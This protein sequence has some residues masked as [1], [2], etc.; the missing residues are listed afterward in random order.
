MITMAT[1]PGST[2][3]NL[4]TCAMCDRTFTGTRHSARLERWEPTSTK[5]QHD[6]DHS[7]MVCRACVARVLE[8]CFSALTRWAATSRRGRHITD[9]DSTE[10]GQA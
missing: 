3:R 5:T 4:I 6:L 9:P 2:D 1:V 8:D 7:P 10:D